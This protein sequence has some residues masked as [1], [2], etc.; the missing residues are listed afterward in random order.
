MNGFLNKETSAVRIQESNESKK[1]HEEPNEREKST[2]THYTMRI[3][4]KYTALDEEY[5]L[6][7]EHGSFN[8]LK[9]Q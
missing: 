4:A 5:S 1:T 2:L 7:I 6:R 8:S 9:N 3:H